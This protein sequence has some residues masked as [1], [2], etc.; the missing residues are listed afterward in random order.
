[1]L[2][3]LSVSVFLA[4]WEVVGR[5]VLAD[6][7]FFSF[8]SAIGAG[9]LEL[10][11]DGD[12]GAHLWA[13]GTVFLF[14]MVLSLLAV[15]V[16]MFMGRIPTIDYLLDQYL[17]ALSAIPRFV[18]VPL[19]MIWFGLGLF[20]K[21]LIIFL[22]AFFPLLFNVREGVKTVDPV[23]LDAARA[24]GCRRWRLY[25]VVIL[26][27]ISSFLVAGLRLGI[28]RA[29]VGIVLVEMYSSRN[30]I[31]FL[32]IRM[33]E[34]LRLD[35]FFAVLAGLALFAVGTSEFLLW[36]ERRLSPWRARQME[37]L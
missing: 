14:G 5:T 30:G 26:P 15:P 19:F 28:G 11:R 29:I 7:L 2:R 16:G 21:A 32:L 13:S 27:S 4:I 12:L 9:F 17:L 34:V 25:T 6:F 24:F 33:A 31:G 35:L 23:L 20:S 1:M 37:K 36:L 10:V 18:F 3:V 8:P 22:G